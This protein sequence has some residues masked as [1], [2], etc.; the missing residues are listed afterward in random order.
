MVVWQLAGVDKD[1][2]IS[3]SA[4]DDLPAY[5]VFGFLGEEPKRTMTVS[6]LKLQHEKTPI[7]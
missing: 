4:L 2:V 7:P 5:F 6:D 3:I 1:V